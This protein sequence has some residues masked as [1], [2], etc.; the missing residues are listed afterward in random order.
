MQRAWFQGLQPKCDLLLSSFG[1]NVYFLLPCST[2]KSM[3]K[4]TEA[5]SQ[6][7]ADLH[8]NEKLM[9]DLTNEC[10]TGDNKV[11]EPEQAMEMMRAMS[12]ALDIVC[13]CARRR[14][15]KRSC[16]SRFHRSARSLNPV[17]T[18]PEW[19]KTLM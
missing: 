14:F 16:L 9:S 19:L 18:T 17:S 10:S 7:N 5:I 6:L 12:D 4:M 3:T 11:M 15:I 1:F 2:V 8:E 13:R